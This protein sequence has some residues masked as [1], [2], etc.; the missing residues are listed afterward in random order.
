MNQERFLRDAIRR[1][2]LSWIAVPKILFPKRDRREFGVRA[3]RTEANEF[4]DA[5]ATRLLD[6]MDAHHRVVVEELS[7]MHPIRADA[8]DHCSSVDDQIRPSASEKIAHVLRLSKVDLARMRYE[9]P[10]RPPLFELAA[11]KT[12]EKSAA[13]GQKDAATLPKVGHRLLR[14]A[15][16]AARRRSA[17]VIRST[18]CS[19]VVVGRHPS[20]SRA[21]SASPRRTSTSVGRK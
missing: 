5:D 7:R 1:I 10:C 19:N 20:R 4:L 18:S 17:S 13:A 21:R 6:Q 15:S 3:N 2:G 8:A 16:S 9:E 12:A 14:C 11:K